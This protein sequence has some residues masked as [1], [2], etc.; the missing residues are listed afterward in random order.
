MGLL[1]K[2]CFIILIIG[3]FIKGWVVLRLFIFLIC[4]LDVLF[5]IEV[6]V[7]V[8][9]ILGLFIGLLLIGW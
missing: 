9:M 3:I 1:G 8:E 7:I 2:L 6:C 4:K 5:I